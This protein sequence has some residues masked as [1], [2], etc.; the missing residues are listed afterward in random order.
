MTR[1]QI[2]DTVNAIIG[3]KAEY[4][5]EYIEPDDA[6]D[7]IGLSSMQCIEALVKIEDEFVINIPG[8]E[9]LGINT[10][11]DIYDIVERKIID[12]HG[13]EVY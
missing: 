10:M 5:A 9:L 3:E 7:E 4:A 12:T 1:Q 2:I 8:I 13:F 6:V 11:Q